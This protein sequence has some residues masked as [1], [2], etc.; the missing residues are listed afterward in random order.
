MATT[1]K[2]TAKKPAKKADTKKA[3]T[4]KKTEANK[5][6]SK[7]TA[8]K[9]DEAKAAIVT[10]KKK[11]QKPMSPLERL[12]ALNIF[13]VV[14]YVILA[15]LVIFLTS[16]ASQKLVLGISAP[17][18]LSTDKASNLAP[19]AEVLFD[20]QYRYVAVGIL[21]LAAIG[22][23]LLA[24]VLRQRYE[25][26][27]NNSAAALRW[28]FLGVT[29]GLTLEFVTLLTGINDLMTLK[30]VGVLIFL[31]TFFGWLSDRD[32]VGKETKW[33]AFIGALIAGVFAWFPA[34][35][36]FIGTTIYGEATFKWYVYAI[37][38]VVLF[39]SL[40]FALSQ[41]HALSKKS[42]AVAYPAREERYIRLDLLTKIVIVIIF[43]AGFSK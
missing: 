16:S 38:G 8:V 11:E 22:S 18:L 15:G 41:Y 5:T 40:L 20:V 12:K 31:T 1:K 7:K 39:S 3:V 4:S 27:V 29:A 26:S 43:L 34:L 9:S 23:L 28:L 32:N 6:A 42:T 37:G 10:T 21:A 14:V 25:K 13:S 35:G 30:V 17:D 36:S 19:A 2:S 24:T 33:L